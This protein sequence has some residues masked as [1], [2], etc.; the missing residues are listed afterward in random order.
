METMS[1]ARVEMT[2]LA[3]PGAVMRIVANV[4]RSLDRNKTFIMNLYIALIAKYDLSE[5]I[6]TACFAR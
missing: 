3:G 1:A 6:C 5:I 2:D 4:G